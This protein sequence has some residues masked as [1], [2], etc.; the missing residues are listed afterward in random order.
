MTAVN[1]IWDGHK[2][3]V[4][5]NNQGNNRNGCA[6]GI[7][8]VSKTLIMKTYKNLYLKIISLKNLYL[9]YKKARKGK[10]KKYYVKE[11]ETNLW[12]NLIILHKALLFQSYKPKPLQTF[13]IKD[14]K[15]RK[16]SKSAFEDRVVHHALC[17]IIEPIFEKVFIFD[18]YANR[19]GK[20]TLVAMQRLDKFKRR[21]SK[22]GK[23]GGW[24]D[25]N[26]VKGF[27]FKAD[28]EH[29]FEEVNHQT[30]LN[31]LKKKINCRKTIWLVKK[32][33]DNYSSNHKTG[34]PLGN[35]T[36]QFFANV[37]LNELDYF[38]K[39]QLKAKYYLRYVDDFLI[40][41]PCKNQLI[42]WKLAINNFLISNLK[43]NLHPDKSKVTSL[44]K[45]ISFVGFR[46][47]YH[48][49]LLK[50]FNRVNINKRLNRFHFLF[51]RNM[52]DY[53][54]IYQSLQGSFAYITHANTYRFK[55]KLS[56][57]I[58]KKFPGQIAGVEIDRY[59][60]YLK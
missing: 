60:K 10:T 42:K 39:H 58:E 54:T 8:L 24:F 44:T 19:K 36:S 55:K 48:H 23:L 16:I 11:F 51:S 46:I 12:Y 21:V 3:N 14:P 22:N 4:N 40:L 18:S 43:I 52:L 9:A 7:A 41:H 59:I 26:Q 32:I 38:I 28:I 29:Y 25:N 47:F 45:P 49:K 20:G 35:L 13:I 17:N 15:T 5:G 31:I 34:M 6:F 30:L 53:D 50:K 37:Y 27:V 2:L 57:Q 1:S 56:T 33:L